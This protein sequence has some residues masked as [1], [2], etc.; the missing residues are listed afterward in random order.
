MKT[1][2]RY[3][4]RYNEDQIV[5]GKKNIVLI[6]MD[7]ESKLVGGIL[8]E[9]VVLTVAKES[10]VD[11]VSGEKYISHNELRRNLGHKCRI[12]Y[13]YQMR[14][15]GELLKNDYLEISKIPSCV[16]VHMKAKDVFYKI[17]KV[18]EG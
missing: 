11:T 3:T 14:V 1:L 5:I 13:H 15:I 7:Q 4:R 18:E 17:K 12:P 9:F 2:Q 10:I 6:K 16:L 8:Y